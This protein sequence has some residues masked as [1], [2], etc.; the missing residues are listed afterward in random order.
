MN[1]L[2]LVFKNISGSTFR[3]WVVG[4]CAL[5]VSG[6][7]MGTL[8]I[9]RGADQSLHKASN[10]LGADILVVPE[11]TVN[12]VESALLMGHP[13]QVWMPADTLQ[14]IAG[15]PG[16]EAVTPQL[17]LSTLTGASCCS[18][19]DM[20][21]VAYDPQTDFTLEPW[22]EDELGGP[23]KLGE[24]VGGTYIFVPE[25]EQNIQLYGY[26]ITLKA[27]LEPTGTGIDQSMFLTFETARDIA[28]ISTMMADS[29]L[30][31]PDDSISAVLV[32]VLPDADT[33]EVALGIMHAVSGVTPIESPNLFRSYRSQIDGLMSGIVL[34]IGVTLLLS[35]LL[36]GLVFSMAANERRR[37][38]GVL[39]SMGASRSFIFK[40]LLSEAGVLAAVGG[41][42]GILLAVLLVYLFRQLIM[43]S[44]EIPFMLPTPLELGVYI[45]SGLLLSLI[46]VA[47]AAL[48]PAYRISHEEPANAMR[49]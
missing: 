41:V 28:R 16:V 49:E 35:V 7:T 13:T 46:S 21:L 47:I 1:M 42:T 4:L 25:G 26:F 34:L 14:K 9:L 29:P 45:I 23:L 11:G 20:F 32:K 30:V 19:S 24:A 31:I 22:L 12:Q 27:N 39:R 43:N 37:E 2:R 8:M 33:N 18:V 40:S 44:L 3:S 15:A 48:I 10:R 6:F 38:L 17:Y 5:L 36:I